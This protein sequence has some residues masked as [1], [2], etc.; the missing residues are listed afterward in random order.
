MNGEA[1][2]G[3][4]CPLHPD[5]GINEIWNVTHYKDDDV[6]D[7]FMRNVS[8]S[9]DGSSV[10]YY[11]EKGQIQ[12]SRLH[13]HLIQSCTYYDTYSGCN[14]RIVDDHHD[15]NTGSDSMFH[16]PTIV[17]GESIYDC[18]WYPNMLIDDSSSTCFITSCRDHPIHLWDLLT[19]DIRCSYRGHNHVDELDPAISLTFNLTGDKIYAGYN[20]MIR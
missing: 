12:S 14:D 17:T 13:D 8:I 7:N 4:A 18:K 6:Y 19:G 16:Y 5:Q 10:L 20:R 2:E 3:P 15:R 9:P 11:N 1:I